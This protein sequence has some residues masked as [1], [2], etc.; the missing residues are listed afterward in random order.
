MR[1]YARRMDGI[2]ANLEAAAA[3]G[4]ESTMSDA[5]T[6]AGESVRPEAQMAAAA[7]HA[8]FTEALLKA[9]RAHFDEIKTVT[10]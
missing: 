1:R 2:A 8:L 10:K 6:S 4:R 5:R 7:D 9:A 3:R